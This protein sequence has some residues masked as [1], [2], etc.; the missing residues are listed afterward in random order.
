VTGSDARTEV[1]RA[2]A[3]ARGRL[4]RLCYRMTGN[5]ADADDLTQESMTKA[6]ERAEQ[7]SDPDPTGW[8]LRLTTHVCLDH[9]RRANVRRRV[10][11]LVDPLDAADLREASWSASPENALV[12][13]ATSDTRSSSRSRRSPGGNARR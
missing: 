2:A 11:E 1:A 4:W 10:T 8:L 12:V 6:I 3:E 7:L 5:R 13:P 9:L